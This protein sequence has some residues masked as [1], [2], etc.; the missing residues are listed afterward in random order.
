MMLQ[1][2]TGAEVAT[3]LLSPSQPSF[4]FDT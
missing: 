4:R 3:S 2:Y 1:T